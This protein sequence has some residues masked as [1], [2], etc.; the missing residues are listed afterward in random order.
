V[1]HARQDGHQ[2]WRVTEG[3]YTPDDRTEIIK[4]GQVLDAV[5]K[6]IELRKDDF[7]DLQQ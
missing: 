3:E 4:E 2:R 1:F 6:A 5:Q 7:K